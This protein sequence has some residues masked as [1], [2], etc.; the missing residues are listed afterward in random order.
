MDCLPM[1][2]FSTE[3]LYQNIISFLHRQTSVTLPKIQLSWSD[4][5]SNFQTFHSN[6][7]LTSFRFYEYKNKIIPI[8]VQIAI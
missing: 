6:S 3:F 8:L 2:W 4:Y 1:N 7:K 5:L